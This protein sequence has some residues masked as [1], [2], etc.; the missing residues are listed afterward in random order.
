MEIF[1]VITIGI[2]YF[3]LYA[4][5]NNSLTIDTTTESALKF[6]DL[7]FIKKPPQFG[8]GEGGVKILFVMLIAITALYILIGL[9]IL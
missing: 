3:M 2:Q 8:R 5:W 9:S 7:K 1:T 6:P 4:L